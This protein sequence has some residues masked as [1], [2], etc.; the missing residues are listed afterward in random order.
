[1]P[2]PTTCKGAGHTVFLSDGY[3]LSGRRDRFVWAQVTALLANPGLVQGE[4]DRRLAELK[5]ANPATAERSRLELEATRVAKSITRLVEAYQEELVSLDELRARMPGLRAKQTG[6]QASLDSLE[7][8]LL[9]QQTYLRL[10]EDLEG[11]PR[12]TAGHG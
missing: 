6:L 3:R 8:Q 12:A 7:A 1:M 2:V 9:D 4:L 10:A 5:S 11:F